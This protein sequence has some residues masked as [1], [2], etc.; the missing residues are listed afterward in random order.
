MVR[1]QV[2]EGVENMQMWRVSANIFNKQF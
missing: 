2:A 1:L